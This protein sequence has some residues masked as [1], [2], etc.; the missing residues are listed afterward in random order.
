L[1]KLHLLLQRDLKKYGPHLISERTTEKI[2]KFAS[3]LFSKINERI[4]NSWDR[5]KYGSMLRIM[6]EYHEAKDAMAKMS[7]MTKLLNI[8]H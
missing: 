1:I 4:P 8:I 5:G 2:D 6:N 3:Q 7:A